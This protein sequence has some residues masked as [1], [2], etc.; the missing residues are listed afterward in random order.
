MRPVFRQRLLPRQSFSLRNLR[1]MMWKNKLGP[2]AVKIIGRSK[3]R[4]RYRRIFDMPAGSSPTPRAVPSDLTR[5]LVLP[6]DKVA[7]VQFFRVRI[8]SVNRQ[9][10]QVL[11]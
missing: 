8:N 11:S 6:Q 3:I 2:T 5:L 1:F 10:F 4:E 9:L 7:W